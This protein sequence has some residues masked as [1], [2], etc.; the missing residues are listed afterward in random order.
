MVRAISNIV[1]ARALRGEF[2]A[3]PLVQGAQFVLGEKTTRD[4]RLI[5]EEKHQIAGI[6]ETADRPSRVRNPANPIT[7]THVAVVV[8]HN[9][10]AI[11]E[12]SGLEYRVGDLTFSFQELTRISAS[13]WRANR[14]AQSTGA[15]R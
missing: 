5:C 1:D 7:C 10:V 9:T 13:L 3:H 2:G 14:P 8:V 4:A 12:R 11:K 15:R 6:V